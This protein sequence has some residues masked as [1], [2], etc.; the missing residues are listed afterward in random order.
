MPHHANIIRLDRRQRFAEAHVLH[1]SASM[2]WRAVWLVM[3]AH[4]AIDRCIMGT[5]STFET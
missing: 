3:A 2:R 4:R 5:C 1:Q